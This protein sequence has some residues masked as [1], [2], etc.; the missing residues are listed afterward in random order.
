LKAD[1]KKL[2]DIMQ[3]IIVQMKTVVIN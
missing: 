2:N 3:S 1:N